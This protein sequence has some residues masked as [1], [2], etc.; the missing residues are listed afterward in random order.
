VSLIDT[1]RRLVELRNGPAH[2]RRLDVFHGCHRVQVPTLVGDLF[3]FANYVP[4][5]LRTADGLEIW[6]EQEDAPPVH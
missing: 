4:S 1:R 2:G 5:G 6:I 3:G